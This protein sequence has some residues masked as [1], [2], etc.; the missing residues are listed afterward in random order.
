MNKKTI[1]IILSILVFILLAASVAGGIYYWLNYTEDE[2]EITTNINTNSN[3]NS[4]LPD[5]YKAPV[6]QLGLMIHLEGWKNEVEDQEAFNK[7][8]QAV[9]DFADILNQAGAKGTFEASLEFTRACH[10]WGDN[11]MSELADQGHGIGVHAD[12]GGNP[13]ENL[14]FND[15]VSQ[16]KVMKEDL[17]LLTSQE[18]FHVSGICS[19]QDWV[20]AAINAGYKFTTGG[21]G[22]CA[23]S[24]PSAKRPAEYSN[25]PNPGACHGVIPTELA[26]RLHPWRA[27]TGTDWLTHNPDGGLVILS[28]DYGLKSVAEESS[29]ANP[30]H[31]DEFNQQDIDAFVSEL[32]EAISL[33]ESGK[34]N[35]L[36]H[37]LSIGSA[38]IDELT[39][40]KWLESIQPYIDSGDVEWKTLPEVYQDYITLEAS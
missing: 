37:A 31:T 28:S 16:I 5:V 2:P 34:T 35:F 23:M 22:Y 20:K 36:Y 17:E 3:I 4:A 11:V 38:Q 39:Y 24:L 12:V 1:I 27:S 33:S 29:G 19:E 10:K 6:V 15:F 18:I 8:A 14:S 40:Q 9:R 26:D 13:K 32:E 30:S 25:C 7:H 21:V